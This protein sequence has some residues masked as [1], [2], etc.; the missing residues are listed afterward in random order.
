MAA[1]GLPATADPPRRFPFVTRTLLDLYERGALPA[2]VDVTVEPEYGYATRITYASGNVRTTFGHD[3]GLNSGAACHLARDK[4]YA[5]FF[6]QRDGVACPDGAAFILPWWAERIRASLARRQF[7]ELR[8]ATDAVAYAEELGWPV[9]VKPV[10]GSKGAGIF[11]CETPDQMDA[12]LDTYA[13]KRVR[14]ALVEAAVE[15]PDYRLVILGDQ[16]ISAYLRTPLT[17]V[18]DG[19]ATVL[20]LA[21]ELQEHFRRTGRD[22]VLDLDDERIDICL[23]RYGLHRDAVPAAGLHV[24][25][26]DIS[27]LSTGGTADD[28]TAVVAPRW[29]ALSVQ[30]VA[31]FG[32]TLG[33]V[34]LACADIRRDDAEYSVLEINASPGLDHYAAV[35]ARQLQIVRDLYAQVLNLDPGR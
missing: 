34:D 21:V 25:L 20:E 29:K 26:H 24:R 32:L 10:N 16:L 2:V 11:R 7:T 15:L 12:A 1:T 9:Y 35:G 17:V 6:L 31:S 5:K 30:I 33:G 28:V 14:V 3:L 22:S 27:N 8:V 18:G 19:R 13:D 4:A 23:A